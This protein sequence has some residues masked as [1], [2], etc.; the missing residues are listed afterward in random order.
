LVLEGQILRYYLSL[1][2]LFFLLYLIFIIFIKN[3]NTVDDIIKINK[4][5]NTLSVINKLTYNQNYFDQNI[6]KLIILFADKYYK[7]INYGHFIIKKNSNFFEI[8]D[9]ITKKSNYDYKI[10]IIEG[11]EKFQLET[12]LSIYYEN[13]ETIPYTDL[14][15]NTYIINSSNSISDLKEYLISYKNDFFYQYRD[16]ELIKKYGIKNILI[17]SSLVE[18]EA[19]NK[20]D[21]LLISSVILNRLNKNMKLQ[22]DASVIAAITEGKF[23]LNRALKIKDLKYDHPLNTYVIKGIPIEMICYVG[24]ETIELLLENPKSDF[25]FYFYNI[26]EQ[27]HI[28]SKNYESHREQLNEYRKKIK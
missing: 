4:G 10:T 12:Y 13:Y 21:K 22:I 23:K 24:Q 16:N 26:L 3:I 15:A 27:K 1:F 2:S 6:F 19:K 14:I 9:I 28:F 8:L 18:K 5:E 11:W 17:L 7:S 20:E 25:L